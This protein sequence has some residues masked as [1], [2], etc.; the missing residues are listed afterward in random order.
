MFERPFQVEVD[1]V[2]GLATLHKVAKVVVADVV[3]HGRSRPHCDVIYTDTDVDI[4]GGAL[5][6]IRTEQSR[7][8]Q[9]RTLLQLLILL[10]SYGYY[11][12]YFY[13]YYY[14]II[15]LCMYLILSYL[16]LLLTSAVSAIIW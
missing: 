16:L 2:D 14:L 4:E 3:R 5:T 1:G 13:Y 15:V 8:E 7:A 6:K 10:R 9:N 11:W 12:R